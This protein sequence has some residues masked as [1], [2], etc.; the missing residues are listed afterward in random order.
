MDG[1][2]CS[3]SFDPAFAAEHPHQVSLIEDYVERLLCHE[4][5]SLKANGFPGFFSNLPSDYRLDRRVGPRR[6]YVKVTLELPVS[7]E[8]PDWSGQ[9]RDMAQDRIGAKFGD[10]RSRVEV[11]I[12]PAKALAAA[13]A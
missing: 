5:K 7:Q 13:A 6:I 12:R 9:L 11:E 4:L 10:V 8:L 2:S 3:L 1:F